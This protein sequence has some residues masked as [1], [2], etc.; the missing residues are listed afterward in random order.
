MDFNI[1]IFEL[2]VVIIMIILSFASGS[3]FE[4]APESFNV[5]LVVFYRFPYF[6]E[7]RDVF[8]PA[9]TTSIL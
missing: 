6:L 9:N 4:L 1:S 7:P 2:I 8:M 3:L 5:I